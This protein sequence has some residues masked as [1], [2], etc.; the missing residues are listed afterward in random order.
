MVQVIPYT[1]GELLVVHILNYD[2]QNE[3]FSEKR[4]FQIQIH[5]PEGFSTE[6]K[7]LTIVSP[8]FDGEEVIEFQQSENEISFTVPILRVWDVGILK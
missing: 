1:S 3:E 4:D 2:F 6:G 8:E 5:I 7:T